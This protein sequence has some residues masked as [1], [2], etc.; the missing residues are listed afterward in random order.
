MKNN[1]I[2]F[3]LRSRSY[4][5]VGL[6][7]GIA[8]PVIAQFFDIFFVNNL[9]FE[10]DSVQYIHIENPLHF[11]LDLMPPTSACIAYYLGKN[12]DQVSY[13][14]ENLKKLVDERTESLTGLLS[15]IEEA[16]HTSASFS[17]RIADLSTDLSQLANEQVSVTGKVTNAVQEITSG[18]EVVHESIAEQ[19]EGLRENSSI[20]GS[21]VESSVE[22]K[23]NMEGL[24]LLAKESSAKAVAG[25]S[26]IND[27]LQAMN[28]IRT[29]SERISEIVILIRDISDQT[30]LLS[31]N[32]SIEAARA[33][34]NGRGFAVVASEVSKL[35]VRTADSV[36]EIDK[37]VKLT[38]EAVKQGSSQF[39][40]AAEKFKDIIAQVEQ[41]DQASNRLLE[42][43]EEQTVKA[44]DM[45]KSASDIAAIAEDINSAVYEQKHSVSV[46]NQDLQLI[47][48]RSESVGTASADLKNLV[49][50]LAAHTELLL[51][52]FRQF[53]MQ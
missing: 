2:N 23:K 36:K 7:I 19:T 35:A 30:N 8:F 44:K 50:D 40:S 17:R 51:S 33:G 32:A 9:Y 1:Y 12:A 14:S 11:F 26:V 10:W 37:L 49:L 46:V 6:C 52:I 43:V 45:G 31:L 53:R 28:V 42:R 16:S 4:A 22:M 29:Q 34:D 5:V 39:T 20:S 3:N 15:K 25:D 21:L 13:Y 38:N 24:K 41:I 27:A 47:Q 48:T 18:T